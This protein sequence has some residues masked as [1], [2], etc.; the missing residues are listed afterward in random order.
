MRIWGEMI[1][2]MGGFQENPMDR[3]AWQALGHRVTR[4]AMLEVTECAR[5]RLCAP[6]GDGADI[7]K[8]PARGFAAGSSPLPGLHGRSEKGAEP[9]AGS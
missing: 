4:L 1:P 3:G 6:A 5:A 2:W 8:A 9:V 7:G